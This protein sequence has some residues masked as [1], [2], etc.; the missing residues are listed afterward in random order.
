MNARKG[1]TPFQEALIIAVACLYAGIS[2]LRMIILVLDSE[3]CIRV[4]WGYLLF[5]S[6][7]SITKLAIIVAYTK[8]LLS[9]R[10]VG[11]MY[12]ELVCTIFL[13]LGNFIEPHMSSIW[14]MGN[15]YIAFFVQADLIESQPLKFIIYTKP[16]ISFVIF[17]FAS[18]TN[19]IRSNDEFAVFLCVICFGVI[20]VW[21][22]MSV[23]QL[24]IKLV[25][26]LEETQKQLVTVLSAVPVGIFVL[27]LQKVELAN[28]A[29]MSLL[30]CCE[31]SEILDRIKT[32]QYK[33]DA[34]NPSE[35]IL[36]DLFCFLDFPST[37]QADFGQTLFNEKALQ[38][39][40]KK[41]T[42]NSKPAVV[43]V[44]KDVTNVLKLERTQSESR[45]KNVLLR[46]VSHELKTPT[47]AIIHSIQSLMQDE[48]VTEFVKGKLEVAEVSC[49]HL[50]L[51]IGDLLDYS[52]LVSA[53]FRLS[54]T[55]FNLRK[56]L[57]DSV[58]LMRLIAHKKKISLSMF[59]DPL[60]PEVVF[61]D[62]N[63]LS[64]V[65]LNLL[66]NAV[67]FTNKKGKIEVLATLT[68]DFKLEVAVKDT[69]VG[70]APKDINKLF[71]TF[72]TLETS[73]F[74]NP[75]G[76]GLGLHISNMLA[77]QLGNS[78]IAVTSALNKGSCFS[79]RVSIYQEVIATE[80]LYSQTNYYEVDDINTV[81][82][83][84]S[85]KLKTK[86]HQPPVLVV[87][88]APFNRVV[89]TEVLMQS[90]VECSEA[91]SGQEAL[92]YVVKRAREGFPVKLVIM[93]YEM[94]IMNG[95]T[96]CKAIMSS[97]LH[98]GFEQPKVIAYTAYSSEE[99]IKVCLDSGMVDFLPK[100]SHKDVLLSIV[101]KYI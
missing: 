41:T 53:K 87:D 73:A 57:N 86:K 24:K 85:F 48:T 67:K 10:S 5:N 94:P 101:R 100:P 47:N 74:I 63:R 6:F 64:Q 18:G 61:S 44:I 93:D 84:Y 96:A 29:C 2:A 56:V 88:D 95:P 34:D 16:L 26:T 75:H 51:I 81:Q 20:G 58:E 68:D 92:E 15:I 82:P 32:L 90:G 89:L 1:L 52:Q 35:T 9:L 97:L 83:V 91:S 23:E 3:K 98:Q 40:G 62:K 78:T 12:A 71:H 79:F 8:G 42:W 43:V 27:T 49:K 60:L 31:A 14:A 76:T 22:A 37:Q 36:Q 13:A 4:D 69:G 21:S 39:I 59:F 80:I 70:I 7:C 17:G 33:P 30:D 99:D 66:S 65:L 55:P 38:W 11:L 77:K 25:Q 28:E 54:P 50:L 72:S 19:E 45:F 46:S